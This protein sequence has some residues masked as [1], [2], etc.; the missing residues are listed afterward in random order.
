MSSAVPETV[1]RFI[2]PLR[3]FRV[4]PSLMVIL[5]TRSMEFVAPENV[6]ENSAPMPIR[7]VVALALVLFSVWMF[8]DPTE[9]SVAPL[10]MLMMLSS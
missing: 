5:P 4:A 9:S 1:L 3:V 2:E 7:S 10:P 8:I 6:P